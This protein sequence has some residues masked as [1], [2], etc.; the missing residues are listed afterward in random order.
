MIHID[1]DWRH[2]EVVTLQSL[3]ATGQEG[4]C[5]VYSQDEVGS[6]KTLSLVYGRDQ[7]TGGYPYPYGTMMT[8]EFTEPRKFRVVARRGVPVKLVAVR[9]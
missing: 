4:S 5:P 8:Y 7:I 3:R 2:G 9:S 6:V 1:T